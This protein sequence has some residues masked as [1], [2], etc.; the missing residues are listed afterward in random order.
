[1]IERIANSAQFRR[2]TRLRELLL[3]IGR[4]AV[5]EGTSEIH[6]QDIGHAV[7][8]RPQ[9]YDTNVDNIVRTSMSE[10]R[11]RLEAYFESEAG[12]LEPL[13]MD[14]PRGCYIPAFRPALVLQD[15]V[16]AEPAVLQPPPSRRRILPAVVLFLAVAGI[17]WVAGWYSNQ[18]AIRRPAHP[19][20]STPAVADLWS[21][22]LGSNQ[23]T[24][25]VMA[26][27]SFLLVETADRHAFSFNEY[28]SR[29]Y[30]SQVLDQK[31]TPE[32]HS[33][34]SMMASKNLG[35]SSEF[36]LV[37][38]FLA[39]DPGNQGIHIYNAREYMPALATQD[40]VILL[41]SGIAN[42]WEDLFD[43]RLNFKVNSDRIDYSVVANRK[44][45]PGEQAVYAPTDNVGYC[46]VAYIPNAD[47]RTKAL[48]IE[49]T[50]SEAV[51]AAGDFLLSEEKLS[52]FLR[53]LNTRHFPYF[54]VLLRTSQVR[55]TPLAIDVLA[56]RTYS[57]QH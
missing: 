25:M 27:T 3:Y 39:L 34:L 19:W 54:E 23:G 50:S 41:G 45:M 11:K 1:L 43:G 48:L 42:P 33:I 51:E 21:G 38:R 47:G 35:S 20:R 44:P 28:L 49:G 57:D 12:S 17:G 31:T 55:S 2:A 32:M 22:F 52:A 46:V 16:A 5:V 29:S 9:S 30:V 36:K 10:L 53:T 6:E 26:D 37:E 18:F 15:P 14:V 8:G 40:N 56:Y 4:T 24:D 13:V 7:F